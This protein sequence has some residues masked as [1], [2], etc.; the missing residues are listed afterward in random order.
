[1]S[2]FLNIMVLLVLVVIALAGCSQPPGQVPTYTQNM[3]APN[4]HWLDKHG[5]SLESRIAY[6][7]AVTRIGMGALA[8]RL[9]AL[10]KKTEVL[11]DPVDPND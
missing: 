7:L 9:E 10:E 8:R 11:G 3:V 2:R 1:M 6:N 5:D 4:Q